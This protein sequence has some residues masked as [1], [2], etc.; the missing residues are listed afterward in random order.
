MRRSV[1]PLVR[2]EHPESY[3]GYPFITLIQYSNDT[4]LTIVDNCTNNTIKAYVLDLCGP[5]NIDEE[6]LIRVGS[7]WFENN[8][9]EYPLSIEFSKLGKSDEVHKV[10]RNI[11]KDFVTRVIGPLPQFPMNT[12]HKIKR[13]KR[14]PISKNILIDNNTTFVFPK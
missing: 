14:R 10:L 2:E 6:I 5:E 1:V 3:N 12:V 8:K 7:V 13:K 4:M 9:E 11:N